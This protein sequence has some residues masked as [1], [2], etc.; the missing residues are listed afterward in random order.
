MSPMFPCTP[1]RRGLRQALTCTVD[2]L[3]DRRMVLPM[4]TQKRSKAFQAPARV[5]VKPLK[6]GQ[7]R[8]P[9]CSRGIKPMRN[10]KFYRHNDESGARCEASSLVR[11]GYVYRGTGVDTLAQSA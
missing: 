7:R 6:A 3:P 9:M 1:V 4:T 8:C 5:T 2:T 10:G 11:A